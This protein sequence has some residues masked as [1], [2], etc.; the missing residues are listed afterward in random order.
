MFTIHASHSETAE[1]NANLEEVRD[2]FTDIKNFIELM[3]NIES[4]HWD[5]NDVAHWKILAEVPFIGTFTEKFAV[6]ETEN[7][8]DLIEWS[9]LEGEKYNLMRFSSEF[10]PKNKNKTM[11]K[12][13]QHLE[14]RRKSAMD[15]H[16]LAGFAGEA[17]I[18]SEM[19]KRVAEMLKVFI[20]KAK[21]ILESKI[22]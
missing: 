7:T 19:N 9:P 20:D 5:Y 13:S 3:P 10:M 18:S 14:L 11:I 16:F 6:Y 2:F 4:I 21:E 8:E 12:F 15:L 22:N 1:I 17:L